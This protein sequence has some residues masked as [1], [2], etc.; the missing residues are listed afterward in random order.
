ME[1]VKLKDITNGLHRLVETKESTA[2]RN[3]RLHLKFK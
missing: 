3:K 2:S 1:V